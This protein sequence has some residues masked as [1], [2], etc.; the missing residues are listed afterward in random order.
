MIEARKRRRMQPTVLALEARRLLSNIVVTNTASSGTG[1]LA[2]AVGQANLNGGA[3]TIT[4]DETVFKTAQ[5]IDLNGSRLELSDTS[6]TE[7][8]AGPKAGVT[9]N[10]GGLS[11]VFAIDPSAKASISGLTIT[12]GSSWVGGGVDNDLGTVALTNCTVSGNSSGGS[13]G[14][15][16]NLSGTVA[17]TNCTVSGNSCANG[18]GAVSTTTGALP[19]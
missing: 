5:T 3:E 15:V 13:G 9:V 11:G 19:R 8:I 17:L 12:G 4:F 6:G 16:Y 18:N 2:W 7:T 10:G 1:S 14:G